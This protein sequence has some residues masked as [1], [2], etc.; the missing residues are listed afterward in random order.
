MLNQLPDG[1]H[2]HPH[3]LNGRA[4]VLVPAEVRDGPGYVS[5]EGN[6]DVG[7]VSRFWFKATGFA[8]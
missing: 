8:K 5:Q 1:R 7:P 2:A 4:G 3:D 6:S